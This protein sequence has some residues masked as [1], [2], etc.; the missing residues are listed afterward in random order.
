[1]IGFWRSVQY[2]LRIVSILS[3]YMLDRF[4]I[5]RYEQFSLTKSDSPSCTPRGTCPNCQER[6][7]RLFIR[8]T[9]NLE[10]FLENSPYRI[11]EANIGVY[12]DI[13]RCANCDLYFVDRSNIGEALH[14]YYAR[15]RLDDV[16]VKDALGRRHA[17]RRVLRKISF[18]NPS[19]K[20]LLDIGCGPGFFL[21]EAKEA[22]LDVWGLE[23]SSESAK[24]AK[25]KLDLFHVFPN[26]EALGEASPQPFDAITAFDF[27]EHA[28]NPKEVFISSHKKLKSGGLLVITVPIIDSLAARLLGKRWHAFVPSHLN[29]FTFKSLEHMYRPLGYS[30]I[31][32]SWHWKYLSLSY[33]IKRLFKKPDWRLPKILDFIIPVNF[34]DEAEVYLR[35][36]NT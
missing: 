31:H 33:V 23:I 28:L 11:T 3:R 34:F 8:G 7:S 32:K 10:S 5:K 12:G 36:E 18:L 19:M 17:F 14:T 1:M 2:G 13:Y 21:A 35:K 26:E 16:Y 25:E 6:Q 27:V 9:V 29:Y 20:R 15:Q 4:G 30:L 22:G 24:F